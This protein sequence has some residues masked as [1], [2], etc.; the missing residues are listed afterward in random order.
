MGKRIFIT[1]CEAENAG[2]RRTLGELGAKVEAV[3]I[4]QVKIQK[5]NIGLEFFDGLAR[6]GK[7]ASL[8]AARKFLLLVDPLNDARPEKRMIV[9]D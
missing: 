6:L 5:D 4:G 2:I 8:A 7:G 1:M 3:S 9:H